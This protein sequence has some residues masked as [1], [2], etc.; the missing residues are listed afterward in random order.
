MQFN[1]SLK[2]FIFLIVAIGLLYFAISTDPKELNQKKESD[3]TDISEMVPEEKYDLPK[4]IYDV[5]KTV[6]IPG[7][8][9]LM[10]D[11]DGSADERPIHSVTIGKFYMDET[12]VT[13]TDFQKYV[14]AGGGKTH[15]WDYETYNQPEHPVSGLNW[16]HA[17]DYCNWRSKIEGFLPAYKLT[18]KLDAWG[19]PL[20]EL[21]ALTDGYRLPTEAEFEYAARGGLEEK[22][23][24]W[25][26]EFD[27]SFANYD[28]ER[29]L[30]KGEWWRLAKVKDTH[31]NDYGLYGMS[32][33][34][35]HW[36]NDWYDSN[37]YAESVGNNP[38]GPESGKTKV[39]RG[40][41]WGSI[42]SD[43]LRVA[44]RSYMAPSNYN[45]DVGFRCVRSATKE[46]ERVN[47]TENDPEQKI[48]H[49]FYRY[50]TS[51]YE[52]PVEID[53]YGEELIER[54]SQFIADY[55]PNSIYF[56]T[57]I[58][59]QEIITPEQM[60]ELIVEVTKEYSIHPLFLAGIMASE[61]GF[62]TCS[63]PRWYNNPM[64]YH[65]QNA[66]IKNG[67]PVYE[68]TSYYNRKYKNLENGFIAFAN[69]IRRNIYFNAAKNDLDA[70]HLVY[71]GY[72]ADEWMYTISRIYKDVLGIR[73]EPNF[74]AKDVGKLIYTDW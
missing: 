72:R 30:M 38:M 71:V 10:G 1:K 16:Y 28:N 62:G 17:I 3:E 50:E 68:S 65:W 57:K 64:A 41:S 48:A 12:P 36:T 34:I 61:S 47:S 54:L 21:G 70:F 37:Y 11:S 73:L 56:Q 60:A 45:Y 44:K 7:G 29:G 74:P 20:W 2:I 26:N 18:D 27:P 46:T 32:G 39:L 4:I 42:S 55:Y 40:G 69:G 59:E 19:Y 35:W 51:H 53:P 22:Q 63:F 15:Y 23:F 33:N 6:L 14:D 31:S 5:K 66:L 25:G 9:F 24:P 13:Y 52:N 43:Y 49:E 8:T 58:D 67:L